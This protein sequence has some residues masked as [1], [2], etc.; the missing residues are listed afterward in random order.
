MTFCLGMS[1][2]D[3]LVGIAD[4]RITSGV[5]FPIDVVIYYNNTGELVEHRYEFEDFLDISNWWQDRLRT[6][7]KELP[8]EWIEN[9]AS[10]LQRVDRQ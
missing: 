1:V 2:E 5:Y 8:S 4:T 9:V 7:V 3:G 10:K 6:S